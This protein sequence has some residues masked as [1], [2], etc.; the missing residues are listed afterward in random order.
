MLNKLITSKKS[1]LSDSRYQIR[2]I[3]D[4]V[5]LGEIKESWK[6]LQTRCEVDIPFN[7]YEWYS[8]WWSSFKPE[9][10]F[11][12]IVVFDKGAPEILYAILPI[13]RTYLKKN[14]KSNLHPWCNTHSYRTGLICDQQHLIAFDYI[15]SHLKSDP[16]WNTFKIPYLIKNSKTH[17]AF[18]KAIKNGGIKYLT[19]PDKNSPYLEIE[20]EWDVYFNK[21]GSS[22]R[23]SLRRKSRKLLEKS[24]AKVDIYYGLTNNVKDS[25]NN[26]L[27]DCWK[28]SEKTWKHAAGSS[29]A[30]DP[31]RLSFYNNLALR[32]NTWIIVPILYLENTPI[33]FEYNLLYKKTLYNLKL[34]Y[35]VEFKKLSPGIVLRMKVLEWAF[36]RGDVE[37]FD[38][39]GNA[40]EYKN[41]FSSNELPHEEMEVYSKSIPNEFR[42]FYKGTLR[43]FLAKHYRLVKRIFMK[44]QISQN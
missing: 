5:G 22:R 30:S 10:K 44:Q 24:N 14:G 4:L 40:A 28:I 36:D 35:D 16:T 23:E 42:V 29:I 20:G 1:L 8:T 31:K 41:M 6:N 21:Q 27:N 11:E 38:Y 43:P 13:Y 15:V 18:K 34:G 17:N 7:T 37:I 32:G 39:M 2:I 12:V 3:N 33:A 9:K 26:K 25:I 19:F